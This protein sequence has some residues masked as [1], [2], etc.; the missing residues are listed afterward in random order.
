MPPEEVFVGAAQK[1]REERLEE[2]L[3]A[4]VLEYLRRHADEK[5]SPRP[6]DWPRDLTLTRQSDPPLERRPIQ[7]RQF[8]FSTDQEAPQWPAPDRPRLPQR[9]VYNYDVYLTDAGELWGVVVF[10]V[11]NTEATAAAWKKHRVAPDMLAKIPIWG[12]QESS[13]PIESSRPLEARET[14]LA[15][16]VLGAKARDR[17]RLMGR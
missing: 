9:C 15:T 12:P 2:F 10:K 7:Y 13:L 1:G 4:K 6:G 17:L 16:L 8:G 14:S 5:P 11:L 3:H